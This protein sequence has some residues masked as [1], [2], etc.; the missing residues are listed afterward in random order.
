MNA[1]AAVLASWLLLFFMFSGLGA[2]PLRLLGRSRGGGWIWFDAF[3][4][5]WGF[6]LGIAQIWHFVFPV[7][8]AFLLL[9]AAAGSVA[10]LARRGE[11]WRMLRRLGSDRLFCLLLALLALWLANRALGMASAY[12]SGFRDMQAV[13]WLDAYP[14]VPGLGNLFASLAF[15][16]SVYL[17]DAL[18]DA[19]VWSGRSQHIATGL[20]LLVY[21]AY[22]L[23]A[24]LHVSR[25]KRAAELRWSCCFAML[26][27]PYALFIG[28]SSGGIAHFLTDT[29]VELLGFVTMVTL[30][31]CLQDRGADQPDT[32]YRFRLLAILILAGFTV[33]QSFIIFGLAVGLF[34]LLV[35]LWRNRSPGMPRAL[36]QSFAPVAIVAGAL[37]LPWLGRGL[38]TSGY[39]AYPQ[40]FGRLDLDWAIPEEQLRQRQVDMTANTRLRGADRGM[41]LSTWD[42]LGPWLRNLL[43]NVMPGL[44]PSLIAGAGVIAY[45]LGCWRSRNAKRARSLSPWALAPLLT[46]L[47]IWFFTFPEPKYVRYIFWS[48]AAVTIVLALDAWSFLPMRALKAAAW[49]VVGLC[50]LYVAYFAIQVGALGVAARPDSGITALPPAKYEEFTTESG[51]IINVPTSTLPQCWRIPLPCTPYPNAS[52]Q[53]RVPGDLRHGF[54]VSAQ[55]GLERGDG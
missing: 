21:L 53:A 7:S 16:Q 42:W 30:L 33:K 3:W 15:N 49:S 29:V 48:L 41:V 46:T 6:T 31:D 44:L 45:A 50:L 26:T 2:I 32:Q 24:A 17:Y 14:L 28:A 27:L 13:M 40:T 38:V 37:L 10:L 8:D 9:L 5:G 19:F 12:D 18:L 1:M 25:C 22:A 55:A 23:K 47:A 39:V 20:L 4:L 34:A 54:R 11:L 52:L 36:A 43:G 51:L 35:W